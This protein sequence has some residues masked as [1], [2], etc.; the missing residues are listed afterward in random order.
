MSQPAPRSVSAPARQAHADRIDVDGVALAWREQGDGIPLVC[1]HAIGHDAEDFEGLR[2]RLA[3]PVRIIALDWPGHGASGPDREPAS[4]ERYAAL[5]AGFLRA[6]GLRDV[7]VLGNSIGGAAALQ[8]AAH[9][10]GLVRALVL[11]NP[12]GLVAVSPFAR[13]FTRGMAAFHAYGARGG[14]GYPAAFSAYY[15]TVLQRGAAARRRREIAGRAR[16]I[17]PIL[18]EAWRSFGLPGADQRALADEIR[19]PVFFAWAARDAVVSLW[20]ARPAIRRFRNARLER[21]AAGHAAF[22][23]TPEAFAASLDRFLGALP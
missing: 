6:M 21:F 10:A 13:A 2:A 7:V 17:A 5:A 23:E 20:L 11:C 12:G 8:L 22:L 9:H 19:Q 3:T 1:L 18:A 16:A 4:A 15:R 14:R